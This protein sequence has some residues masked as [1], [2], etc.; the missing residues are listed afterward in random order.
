MPDFDELTGSGK[1]VLVDFWAQWCQP[2]KVQ[3]PYLEQIARETGD[4][5]IIAKLN[6][7]DNRYIAGREGVRNIP[8]MI[9]YKNGKVVERLDGL[10]SKA[11]II[12]AIEKH[13]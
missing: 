8:T 7:D 3:D 6:V 10:Q 12:N 1:L 2:C 4:D 11:M 13:K 9:L 5:V